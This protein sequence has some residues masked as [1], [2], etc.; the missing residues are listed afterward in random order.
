MLGSVSSTSLRTLRYLTKNVGHLNQFGKGS[1]LHIPENPRDN[2]LAPYVSFIPRIK[3]YLEKNRLQFLPGVLYSTGNLSVLSVR[4]NQLI[5]LLPSISHLRNLVELNLS[6]NCLQWLPYELKKLAINPNQLKIAGNP[7]LLA[8]VDHPGGQPPNH[9]IKVENIKA[10]FQ[11][12]MWLRRITAVTP[13]DKFGSA[14]GA[15]GRTSMFH[16]SIRSSPPMVDPEWLKAYVPCEEP[17][18]ILEHATQV[19]S[20]IETVLRTASRHPVIYTLVADLPEDL[21]PMLGMFLRHALRLKEAERQKCSVCAKVYCVPCT[22]WIEWW[23]F[24]IDADN[25]AWIPFIRFGCSPSCFVDREAR[26]ASM[27]WMQGGR[28]IR[29]TSR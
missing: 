29:R 22:E 11:D 6:N 27:G 28:F 7:L 9:A 5:S 24:G 17:L 16:A 25:K 19:P 15:T 14:R 2:R 18:P 13:L 8:N 1:G 20:L 4:D 21:P 23:S 12:G 10:N 26:E 3:L